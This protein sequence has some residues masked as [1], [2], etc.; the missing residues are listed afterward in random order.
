VY[1]KD[2][3]SVPDPDVYKAVASLAPVSRVIVGVPPETVTTPPKATVT[4]AVSDA[5]KY[6]LSDVVL[7]TFV[8]NV[9][10]LAVVGFINEKEERNKPK[11]AS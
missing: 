7:E 4:V 1:S 10:A 6:P 11:R 3:V 5:V 9:E 2:K 8:T